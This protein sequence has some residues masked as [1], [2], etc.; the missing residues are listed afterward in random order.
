[1]NIYK[2]QASFAQANAK[3]SQNQVKSSINSAKNPTLTALPLSVSQ[4]DRLEN[5][6]TTK[7][8]CFNCYFSHSCIP[9]ILDYFIMNRWTYLPHAIIHI[10]FTTIAGFSIGQTPKSVASI[11]KQE[12]ARGSLRAH[13]LFTSDGRADR[14]SDCEDLNKK[15]SVSRF[16]RFVLNLW[17]IMW[18]RV[19]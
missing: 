15:M 4:T 14:I 19:A 18:V 9:H 7:L 13:G 10:F 1:M 3:I 8:Y 12:K 2:L 5:L 11:F 16:F 17:V 6:M